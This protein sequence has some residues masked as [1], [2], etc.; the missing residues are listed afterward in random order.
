MALTEE[1]IQRY[2]RQILLR[3]VGGRGQVTLLS[4]RVALRGEGAAL[5][6]AA[7]YVAGS[8]ISLVA[9]H[10]PARDEERGFLI[11]AAAVGEPLEAVLAPDA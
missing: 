11:P 10:R 1:Q 2:S 5:A 3:E 9:P 6:T 8:G 4:T 7:A